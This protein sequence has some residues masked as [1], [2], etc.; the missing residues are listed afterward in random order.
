MEEHGVVFNFEECEMGWDLCSVH[1]TCPVIPR[2]GYP[3]PAVG[4]AGRQ[5]DKTK[6]AFFLRERK[7]ASVRL[8]SSGRCT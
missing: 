2:T 1:E 4:E 3:P 6:G 5:A 8:M 7:T